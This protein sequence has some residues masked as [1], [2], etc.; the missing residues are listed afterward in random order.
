MLIQG[1]SPSDCHAPKSSAISMNQEAVMNC[2]SVSCAMCLLCFGFMLSAC[3]GTGTPTQPAIAYVANS[4]SH[5]MSVIKIPA[6]ETVFTIEIGTTSFGTATQI[7]TYPQ[8]VAVTPDGSRAYVT[9]G[10]ASVWVVDTQTR[11]VVAIVPAGTSPE[12]VVISPDGKS[13]YITTQVCAALTC[14]AVVEVVNTAT[15]AVASTIPITNVAGTALSGITITPDGTRVYVAE[16]AGNNVFVIDTATNSIMTTIP[17]ANSGSMDI[18]SSPDGSRVYA[19]GFTIGSPFDS[20]FVDVIDTQSNLVSGTIELGNQEE[21]VRIAVTPDGAHAYVTGDGG[22][23]FVV[24]TTKNALIATIPVSSGKPLF[25]V[26]ITPDG[27]RAYVTC[28]DN[29][30]IFVLSTAKNEVVGTIPSHFPLGMAIS[31]AM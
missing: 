21:P 29:N 17:T 20:F 3:S 31:R 28:G 14:S 5:K 16:V 10:N 6:D 7:P 19:T 30:T 12:D 8:N 26:A 4:Q 24:D 22:H 1:I 23:V 18:S 9:D 2:R 15:N 11:S 27:A 13:A 25:G